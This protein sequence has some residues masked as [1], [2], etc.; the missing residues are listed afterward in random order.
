MELLIHFNLN[1]YFKIHAYPYSI[2]LLHMSIYHYINESF[3]VSN[4]KQSQCQKLRPTK[5]NKKSIILPINTLIEENLQLPIQIPRITT[6]HHFF[7]KNEEK[8]MTALYVVLSIFIIIVIFAL[9]MYWHRKRAK[10]HHIQQLKKTTTSETILQV[11]EDIHVERKT[12][13]RRVQFNL[14]D[15]YYHNTV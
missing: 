12:T 8:D 11:T 9:S 3:K 2:K 13:I 14:D 6:R 10:K 1:D 4:K 7:I 5:E 15:N